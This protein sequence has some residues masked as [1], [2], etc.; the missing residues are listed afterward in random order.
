MA[1]FTSSPSQGAS[2]LPRTSS[3]ILHTAVTID[4]TFWGPRIQA[5]REQTL[6]IMYEQSGLL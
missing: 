6:P 5:V 1:L 4:D 2:E 3:P